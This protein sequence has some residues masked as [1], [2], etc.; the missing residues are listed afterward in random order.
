MFPILISSRASRRVLPCSRKMLPARSPA[1]RASLVATQQQQRLNGAA[2]S[3]GQFTQLSGLLEELYGL[4]VKLNSLCMMIQSVQRVRFCAQALGERSSVAEHLGNLNCRIRRSL[5]LVSIDPN[6]LPDSFGERAD[7]FCP[8]QLALLG[9]Q[10]FSARCILKPEQALDQRIHLVLAS[11]LDAHQKPR[12]SRCFR[13]RARQ[14][15][16]MN[17]IDPV[18]RPSSLAICS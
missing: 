7:H 6:L 18:A 8:G 1:A 13:S 11:C 12:F 3:A 17:P 4:F 10:L 9:Y 15:P 14:R 5:R 16:R 2:Q